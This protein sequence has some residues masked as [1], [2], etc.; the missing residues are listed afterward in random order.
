VYHK[1][2]G[3]LSFIQI[4][5]VSQ[6]L[7]HFFSRNLKCPSILIRSCPMW[8]YPMCRHYPMCCPIFLIWCSLH[9]TYWSLNTHISLIRSPILEIFSAMNSTLHFLHIYR[10]D[11]HLKKKI[12]PSNFEKFL[13]SNKFL[14]VPP[15]RNYFLWKSRWHLLLMRPW[16]LNLEYITFPCLHFGIL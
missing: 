13:W 14:K 9:Y 7:W 11:F 1:L 10:L 5:V 6:R 15:C 8:H 4:G 12:L 3:K 16:A 2:E